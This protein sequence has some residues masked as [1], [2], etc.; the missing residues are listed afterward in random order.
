MPDAVCLGEAVLDFFSIP[1]GTPLKTARRFECF[2]GGAPANVAVA[3]SRLGVQTGF[4]GA[5]GKDPFGKSLADLLHNEGVEVRLLQQVEHVPTTLAFVA[6]DSADEQDFIIYRSADVCLEAESLD[7]SYL[8]TAKILVYNSVT[9]SSDGREAA[10][11]AVEWVNES[12]GLVCFDANWRP[13]L[14]PDLARGKQEIH[15]GIESATLVKVNETELELL[16]GTQEP[17]SGCRHLLEWGGKL[18]LATLGEQGSYYDN[19]RVQGWV[20]GFQVHAVDGTGCGDAFLAAFLQQWLQDEKPLEQ[21]EKEEL[22]Q[23]VT[24]AN[25]A[26]ALTV[27]SQSAMASLPFPETIDRFLERS[28]PA[29][30]RVQHP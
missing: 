5:V 19:G 27:Q 8:K 16:T 29:D 2:P 9:L 17:A 4:I 13:F 1:D 10:M 20:P 11:Q 24:F 23:M 25:A 12:T 6:K 18:C 7:E 28:T 14:W 21:L 30:L 3:L 22:N 15:R 26:G